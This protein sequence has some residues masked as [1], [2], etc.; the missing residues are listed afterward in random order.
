MNKRLLNSLCILNMVLFISCIAFF[1]YALSEMREISRKYDEIQERVQI[2]AEENKANIEE[3]NFAKTEY[4]SI[5]YFSE[6]STQNLT[7]ESSDAATKKVYFQE[8]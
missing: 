2:L 4:P 3:N 5:E 7:E 8:N 6:D 1:C